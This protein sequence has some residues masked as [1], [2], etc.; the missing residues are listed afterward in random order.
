M[1]T[2]DYQ[3]SSCDVIFQCFESMT[4]NANNPTVPHCP[5]CDPDMD[6]DPTL[7]RY[8][9]NS[10]PAFRIEGGGVYNPGLH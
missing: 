7:Y 8:F 1:P 2:Y 5:T 3:C 4:E 6:N 10:R 9:G